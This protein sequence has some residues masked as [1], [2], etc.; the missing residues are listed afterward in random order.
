MHY[1]SFEMSRLHVSDL[2]RLYQ[3][4]VYRVIIVRCIT[5]VTIPTATLNELCRRRKN[6]GGV[7]GLESPRNETLKTLVL[8]QGPSE[9]VTREKE[10]VL[11]PRC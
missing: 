8:V 4:T 6:N 3:A 2:P 11:G 7:R 10:H 1:L 9:L 5:S